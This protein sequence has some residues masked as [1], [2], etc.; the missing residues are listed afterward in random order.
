MKLFG[1]LP[2]MLTP[3]NKD[4]SINAQEYIKIARF[5]IK[6]GLNGIFCNGSAGDGLA[7]SFDKKVQLMKLSVE[8]A[9]KEVPVISGIG[10]VIYEETLAL[11]QKAKEIG[12]DALLLQP[13]FYYP[14]SEENMIAYFSQIAKK[15]SLPL[16]IYNI[17]LFAP[18]ISLKV[19]KTL[20]KI[21]NI[22]GMK[23]SSGSAVDFAHFMDVCNF[24][25][26]VGREEYYLGALINGAKGSMTSCGGVFP[27]IMSK[28]YQNFH[29]Q[30]FSTAQKLQKSIIKAISFASSLPFPLGYACLLEARGFN[31]NSLVS[32]HPI[33]ENIKA[34][35]ETKKQEAKKIIQEIHQ[36]V[37][38]SSL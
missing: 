16:Y 3:Y 22:V 29:N 26:F 37:G 21:E 20:S 36:E 17:P 2:A 5:G 23:D 27:E 33:H 38:L 30:D 25:I 19:A 15:V 14:I 28:I 11:A 18:P 7:L 1:T 4:L 24:D 32:P 13:P 9:K 34:S 12:V 6:N 35:F 10:S 8:A 31:F